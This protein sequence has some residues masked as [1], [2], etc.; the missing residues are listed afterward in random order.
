MAERTQEESL[1][2]RIAISVTPTQKWYLEL[3]SKTLGYDGVSPMLREVPFA[4]A[5]AK[6]AH[7]AARLREEVA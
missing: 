2:E 3:A 5:V 1:T 6:G 7:L 4:D